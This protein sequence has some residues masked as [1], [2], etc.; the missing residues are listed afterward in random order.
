M[1]VLMFVSLPE[2]NL[3]SIDP[4]GKQ[5][6]TLRSNQLRVVETKAKAEE[7]QKGGPCNGP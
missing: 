6:R 5:P 4:A 7:N 2:G 3:V 1:V